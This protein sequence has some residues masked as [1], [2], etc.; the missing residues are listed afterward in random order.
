[1]AGEIQVVCLEWIER[2]AINPDVKIM[3]S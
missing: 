2:N 1:L 3:Q